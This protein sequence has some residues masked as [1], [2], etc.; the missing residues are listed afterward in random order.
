M[1]VSA[2]YGDLR[3]MQYTSRQAASDYCA[4]LIRGIP[5]KR[6]IGSSLSK[7]GLLEAT[8]AATPATAEP[9]SCPD[10]A[11]AA[12]NPNKR[13]AAAAS[14]ASAALQTNAS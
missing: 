10:V 12:K 9:A 4:I 8:A 1:F 2:G 7:A 5:S 6:T 3:C 11:P 13:A 14:K